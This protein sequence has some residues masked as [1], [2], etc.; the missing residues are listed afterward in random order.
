MGAQPAR[1]PSCRRNS[2]RFSR[3]GP[4]LINDGRYNVAVN[5]SKPAA[6]AMPRLAALAAE[7]CGHQDWDL[8]SGALEARGSALQRLR[9]WPEALADLHSSVQVAWDGMQMLALVY[10]LWNITPALAR[11]RHG[12]LAAQTMAAAEALW[13]ERFGAFD[14]SDRRHLKR[15][16]RFCRVLL[17][18]AAA[19]AAWQAATAQSGS[20]P[21]V[22]SPEETKLFVQKHYQLYR[23]L[24]ESLNIIDSKM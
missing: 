9:R 12:E 14:T 7:G 17:G 1:V 15:V 2:W 5:R 18:P 13:R 20:L 8:A 21:Y 11:M 23:S 22:K 19:D 24:G 16:R 10:A 6:A 3:S 4:A